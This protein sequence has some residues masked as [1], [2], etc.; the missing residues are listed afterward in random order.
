MIHPENISAALDRV[1]MINMI[2]GYLEG[3]NIREAP[4][5]YVYRAANC[6]TDQERS[7]LIR[8]I[9]LDNWHRTKSEDRAYIAKQII[10]HI[11]QAEIMVA[12]FPAEVKKI[13]QDKHA[14]LK[15]VLL[16]D[17]NFNILSLTD[18]DFFDKQMS[19]VEHYLL[20]TLNTIS[21]KNDQLYRIKVQIAEA[22]RKYIEDTHVLH[23][24][25]AAAKRI[26]N[27]N[28]TS[29]D[30]YKE[31]LNAELVSLQFDSKTSKLAKDLE[32]IMKK[33]NIFKKFIQSEEQFNAEA[34]NQ[35]ISQM[36]LYFAHTKENLT[37]RPLY[38]ISKHFGNKENAKPENQSHTV[39]ILSVGGLGHGILKCSTT[40][41]YQKFIKKLEATKAN[42]KNIG[43]ELLTLIDHLEKVIATRVPDI[44]K[45]MKLS[46]LPPLKL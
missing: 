13:F 12:T 18:I 5:P 31:I 14:A 42:I 40:D 44:S 23:S 24:R 20:D 7:I 21:P 4:E 43:P 38:F 15:L 6:K 29:F 32:I 19:K 37:K 41:D 46:T 11:Y 33:E 39:E 8:D 9:L 27:I 1:K 10:K 2:E 45:P 30:H 35:Y 16:G 36:L 26:L 17:A 3:D 25:T 28:A 34:L 22:M